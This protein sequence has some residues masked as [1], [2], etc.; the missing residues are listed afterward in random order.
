MLICTGKDASSGNPIFMP[1]NGT[2]TSE[3]DAYSNLPAI[4]ADTKVSLCAS[5]AYETQKFIAPS[6]V[7]PQPELMFLQKQLCNRI[8]SDYFEA[9][10]KK[11]PFQDSVIAEAILRQF[12]LESCRTAWAGV[13]SKFKV[14]AL[15]ASLG[16]QWDYTSQGLIWQFKR[17][18]PLT[19]GVDGK[20]GFDAIIDLFKFKFTKF[21]SSKKA[22]WLMGKELIAAIQK[23]DITLHKDVTMSSSSVWGIECT[24]LHTVFGDVDLIHDPT[25]DALG[26]EWSGGLIDQDGLVRYFL[27]DEKS[28]TEE[29]VG[30]EA[31]RQVVM[32]I[33]CLCLK[34]YSHVWVDGTALK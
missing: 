5:A 21:G 17:E 22:V 32:T 16:N 3:T 28:M 9:Q 29:V 23:I 15:D 19:K 14:Q 34:G 4:P 6:T 30:E 33:D 25:L 26:Y 2:K 12:R 7:V 11:L 24:K 13:G 18:Y 10:K 31:S 8:V 20:L 27:K 1:V